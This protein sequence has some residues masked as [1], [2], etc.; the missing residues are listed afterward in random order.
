MKHSSS[1]RS[2]SLSCSSCHREQGINVG[3]LPSWPSSGFSFG[4]WLRAEYFQDPGQA[5][6]KYEPRLFSFTTE[7]KCGVEA[8]FAINAQGKAQ[9]IVRTRPSTSGSVHQQTF[10][11]EFIAKQWYFIVVTHK[12]SMLL[13]STLR[14][15]VGGKKVCET[16]LKYPSISRVRRSI[17]TILQQETD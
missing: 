7:D 2:L 1:A 6:G 17:G 8:H 11:Y 10:D 15:F 13:S 14:L 12:Y 5:P 16:S 3:T 4:C 9:L